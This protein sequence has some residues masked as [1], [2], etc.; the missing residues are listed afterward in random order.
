MPLVEGKQRVS[1][2]PLDYYKH[3]DSLVRWKSRLTWGL[4]LFTL[5]WIGS[6][7][8]FGDK[9]I[10]GERRFAHGA[11]AAAHKAIENDCSACHPSF[12]LTADKTTV[13]EKCRTCHL[14]S[15]QDVHHDKQQEDMMSF[16]GRCHPGNE[17]LP[18]MAVRG[19]VTKKPVRT[20]SPTCGHCHSDHHGSDFAMTRTSDR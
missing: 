19:F 7:F 17:V 12:G 1:R 3:P 14:E 9:S 18:L 10:F 11:L 5:L 8:V 20:K 4:G 15:P 16:C 2:I 6:T 13:N